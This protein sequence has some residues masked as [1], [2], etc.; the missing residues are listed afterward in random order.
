M[1]QREVG[2]F[3]RDMDAEAIR[4]RQF[5]CDLGFGKSDHFFADHALRFGRRL[6]PARSKEHKTRRYHDL[7]LASEPDGLKPI[8]PELGHVDLQSLHL[9]IPNAGIR[10]EH[11]QESIAQFV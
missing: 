11:D 9:D 7:R 4:Q 10:S 2:P 3:R 1:P 5:G 6:R 8:G